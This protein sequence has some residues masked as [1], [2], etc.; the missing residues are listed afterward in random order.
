MQQLNCQVV[1][2]PELCILQAPSLKRSLVLGKYCNGLFLLHSH[3]G[4]LQ[5]TQ[6]YN[7]VID[8]V[9]SQNSFLSTD[10]SFPVSN[11][12][13]CSSS[14]LWHNRLGHL[15]FLKLKQ[16]SL[17]G[18]IHVQLILVIFVHKLDNINCHSL[19]LKFILL[20]FL[21]W[22]TLTLG[23][24]ITLPHMRVINIFSQLLMISVELP[25][26]SYSQL[27]EMHLSL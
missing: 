8:T 18:M 6:S 25:G 12:I 1:F 11:S 9:N 7:P 13:V 2:T 3:Q 14:V 27:R 5:S 4:E 10:I 21:N 22:F 16:I 20:Q 24:L 23:D 17:L 19:K 26:L 15:P